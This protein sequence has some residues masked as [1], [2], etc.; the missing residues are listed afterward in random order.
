M[1]KDI[2]HVREDAEG[3][4]SLQLPSY[5]PDVIHDKDHTATARVPDPNAVVSPAFLAHIVLVTKRLPE[6]K[7]WYR[8]VLG[9]ESMFDSDKMIFFTFNEDHHQVAIF[10]HD[11]IRPDKGVEPEVCGLHHV[12]FTYATLADLVH[13]YKRLK[14]EGILPM[15]TINHGTTVS[16]YYLDP[17]NNRIEL[18][19]DTFPNKEELNRYLTGRAFNRNPIGVLF[20]FEEVVERFD[21]GDDPWE[22]CSPYLM[23]HGLEDE[24]GKPTV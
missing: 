20:D 24:D 17:D 12:A 4:K 13:T 10:D 1:E 18:Q 2:H 11:G 7:A 5:V 8:T 23:R 21:R 6:M 9:A 14:G 15:R 19:V 16:N 22:I 3:Y